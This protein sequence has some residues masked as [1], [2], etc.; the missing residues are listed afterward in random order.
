MQE[1]QEQPKKTFKIKELSAQDKR[2]FVGF[3]ELL[4]K[5]DKRLNPHLYKPKAIK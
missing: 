1:N 3:F 5:V 2:N 4:F